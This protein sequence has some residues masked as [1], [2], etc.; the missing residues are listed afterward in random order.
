MSSVA[1]KQSLS[2]I[3]GRVL[4]PGGKLVSDCVN[5]ESDLISGFGDSSEY[6]KKLDASG[7]YVVPGL[8]DIHTHGI[9]M[10]SASGDLVAYAAREAAAGAT[11]FFPTLF[12]PADM[13]AE[14]MIRHLEET[15]SLR[16]TPNVGGF[17]LESPYLAKSGGGLPG[18]LAPINR[19]LTEKMLAAGGGHIRIWDVSPELRGAVQEILYLS[20]KNI[21]CGMAHTHATIGQ[22]R[23]AVDAGARLVTH[24]FDTFEMPEDT[25][26]TTGVYPAGLVD[27]LL[28][29]DR[30]ACEI[31]PDG[32]HVDPMLVEKTRRCK[33]LQGLV[34]VTDGNF[35]AGLPPGE[36]DLPQRWG[37]CRIDGPNNGVRLMERGLV[38]SGSA[39]T[40]IDCFRNAI[41]LFGMNV[42]EASCLCSR[43]PAL[44]LGLNK[45][46]ISMGRDADMLI[47]DSDL[48]VLY[49]IVAGKLIYQSVDQM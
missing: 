44:L 31:I 34:F 39:L 16:L 30:V 35:G 38:L 7:G 46:E 45:G 41:R 12:G 10:E 6:F 24:L 28:I 48:N 33:P 17:H 1:E 37:R 27:Y 13:I 42:A 29:E 3:N 4:T 9:G 15:D 25:A 47:L 32:T 8:I 11:T 26:S 18:D 19:E 5:I 21:V 20:T 22:A 2:I 14:W 36:Y 43:N 49:V 40:P 23:A